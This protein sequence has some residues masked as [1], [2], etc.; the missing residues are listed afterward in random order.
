[1][2]ALT[3][4]QQIRAVANRKKSIGLLLQI[5]SSQMLLSRWAQ[6]SYISHYCLYS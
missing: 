6:I 5:L 1:V 2:S 4:T 3:V